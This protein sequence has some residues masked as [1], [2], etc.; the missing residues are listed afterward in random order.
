MVFAPALLGFVPI[1]LKAFQNSCST[2]ADSALNTVTQIQHSAKKVKLLI[3]LRF[4]NIATGFKNLCGFQVL[5][6]ANFVR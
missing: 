5:E 3:Y 4:N 1:C 2:L 6:P